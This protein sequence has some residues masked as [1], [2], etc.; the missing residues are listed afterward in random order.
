MAWALQQGI[1]AADAADNRE[2]F[3]DMKEKTT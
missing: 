2:Q 3:L 1:R